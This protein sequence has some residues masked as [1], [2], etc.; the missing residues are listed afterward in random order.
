MLPV[1]RSPAVALVAAV[2]LDR[3]FDGVALQDLGGVEERLEI[4]RFVVF[5]QQVAFDQVV[6]VLAAPLVGHH[7][8]R[9]DVL[10]AGQ[11]RVALHRFE[12]RERLESVFAE[13][14][15]A[16]AVVLGD[17]FFGVPY[18]PV[19]PVALV[20]VAHRA[21]VREGRGGLVTHVGGV[22][23]HHLGQHAVILLLVLFPDDVGVFRVYFVDVVFPAAEPRILILVVAA[24]V[25]HAGVV[26]QAFDVVDGLQTHVLQQRPFG[27]VDRA[28]VHEILPDQDAL[29]VAKL[30]E[31]VVF[32]DAAA[33]DAEHVHVDVDRVPDRAFVGLAGDA[34]QE[35]VAGDVVG[36]LAENGFAVEQEPQA[37]SV[38]VGLL[39]DGD[40]AEP[41][42]CAV[43]GQHAASQL[44]GGTESIE[45][46]FA[47]AAAPP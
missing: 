6:G 22:F 36:A 20:V 23:G 26:A 12:T 17:G 1:E 29:A 43:A 11:R 8:F 21:V 40:G 13:E 39:L 33:P 31:E 5:V 35:A 25:D 46:R 44:H 3:R 14:T 15:A 9:R 45:V 28:G 27:R 34:G 2:R 37:A 32:V 4:V 47:H 18:L 38:G 7:D 42:L 10:V 30:I 41:D 19:V 16:L 24:P